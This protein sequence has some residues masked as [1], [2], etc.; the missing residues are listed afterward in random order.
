MFLRE[1]E[2][3]EGG[4]QPIGMDHE[5]GQIID[6]NFEAFRAEGTQDGASSQRGRGYARSR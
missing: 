5:P 1:A 4:F 6:T 2:K 3:V